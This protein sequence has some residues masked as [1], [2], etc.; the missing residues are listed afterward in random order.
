MLSPFLPIVAKNNEGFG[1]AS[2]KYALQISLKNGKYVLN[3]TMN[4]QYVEI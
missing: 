3:L 1:S 4:F 2:P